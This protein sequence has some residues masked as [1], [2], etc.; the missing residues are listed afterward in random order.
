ML[1]YDVKLN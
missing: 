1:E